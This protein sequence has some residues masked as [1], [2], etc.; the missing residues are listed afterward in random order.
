MCFV[1]VG[2]EAVVILSNRLSQINVQTRFMVD[3]NAWPPEQPVS[4]TPLLLINCQGHR[5]PEQ[6]M[7][8]VKLMCS[9]NIDKVAS[10]TDDST[11]EH[12]VLDSHNKV[13]DTNSRAT[14]NIEEFLAPLDKQS[15]AFILIE[16]PRH[17]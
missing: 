16:G 7:A 3:D 13:L 4:Y 2:A 9:D 14:K 12:S 8:M 1:T 5:T 11:T 17:W 10:V 6:V 15:S